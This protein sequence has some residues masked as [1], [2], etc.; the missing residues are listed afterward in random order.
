[1]NIFQKWWMEASTL[2]RAAL[3]AHC[4]TSVE[5]LRQES[6]AYRNDGVLKLSL[7]RAHKVAEGM[8][9]LERPEL[10][11]LTREQLNPLWGISPASRK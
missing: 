3:A 5:T 8:A 11:A 10:K 6:F 1:M 4:S 2:E 9:L 7:E